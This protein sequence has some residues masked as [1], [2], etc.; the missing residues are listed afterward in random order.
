MSTRTKMPEEKGLDHSISLVKEGYNFIINRRVSMQSNVFKTKVLGRSAYCLSG[1]EAAKLFYDE[2]KFKRA[3]AAPLPAKK[4]LFGVGGVQGLDDEA[5]R[6]RKA[7][8]M[9]LWTHE[10]ADRLGQLTREHYAKA[11][12]DWVQQD[13]IVL[14]DEAKKI[15]TQ[16]A[17]DWCGVPLAADEVEKR[18]DQ[19]SLMFEKAGEV[20][21]SHFRGWSARSKAEDWIEDLIDE[22]REG[23]LQLN[24][25]M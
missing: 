1:S 18:T 11:A 13:E 21:F 17:C 6:H 16:V 5:H 20:G 19:L 9:Q 14:Y 3:G 4:T 15:L 23:H 24:E 22:A 10:S 7:M 25:D 12:K 8:F 2:T